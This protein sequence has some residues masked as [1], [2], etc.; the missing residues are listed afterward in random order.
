MITERKILIYKKYKGDVDLWARIG[1]EQEKLDISDDDWLLIDSLIQ[2]IVIGRRNVEKILKE[3]T[4]ND[5][6]RK[7]IKDLAKPVE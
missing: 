6:V 1:T 7:E 5:H 3:N 4:E 2:D